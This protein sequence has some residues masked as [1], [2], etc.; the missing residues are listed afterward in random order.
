MGIPVYFKTLIEDYDKICHSTHATHVKH[1]FFDLN[2]LIHPCCHG[3][4]DEHIM[5]EKITSKINIIVGLVN[6]HDLIYIAID[7][8]CPKPKLMQQKQRR[9]KSSKE[10]KPWDTNK[11]TPGTKFMENLENYLLQHLTYDVKM[12]FSSSNEPGEGE[13]K[14]FKY[15][16]ETNCDYNVVYGLDADLIMLSLITKCKYIYLLRERTEFNIEN[17]PYEYIYLNIN[18][19][20]EQIV[21]RIKPKE[22]NF[23]NDTLINDYIFICFSI[24]NDFIHNSPSINIRYNGLDYLME[25]YCKLQEKYKGCFY[26]VDIFNKELFNIHCFKEFIYELTIEE[27]KRLIHIMKIRQKQENRYK[28]IEDPEIKRNHLPIINRNIEK[29][30]FSD[31]KLWRPRYYLETIGT[32]E[33]KVINNMCN[34]YIQSIYW[35]LHYYFI[36]CIS[37]RFSYDYHVAPSFQDLHNKLVFIDR[38]NIKLDQN[39][40]TPQEQLKI[41][42]P[43]N[44]LNLL[45]EPIKN[46][47]DYPEDATE[48]YLLKRYLWESYYII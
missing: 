17:M 32:Y 21:N 16:R 33:E 11:I 3:E 45:Q 28:Y 14:I 1:L 38:V 13:H 7:G 22:Y 36:G 2:C 23:D 10:N 34:K 31:M 29:H 24:G 42:L 25:I 30:I 41:V 44:S 27:D 37:W 46:I 15:I 47:E 18:K 43:R 48:C 40:Y 35:T 26:I 8:P 19:L 9:F 5:Y 20:K 6:P 4:T 12:I 39:P